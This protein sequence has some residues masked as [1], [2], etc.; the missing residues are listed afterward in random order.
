MCTGG[1]CPEPTPT[2]GRTPCPG[3]SS[4]TSLFSVSA[5]YLTHSRP[6]ASNASRFPPNLVAGG[7]RGGS[8]AAHQVCYLFHPFQPFL[9]TVVQDMESGQPERVTAFA[10]LA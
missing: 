2:G 8:R 3:A 7:G 1:P 6:P 4:S 10:R 5:A 9:L